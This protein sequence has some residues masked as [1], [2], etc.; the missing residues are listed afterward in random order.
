M[1]V[2][3]RDFLRNSMLLYEEQIQDSYQDTPQP[4]R[5]FVPSQFV[6]SPLEPPPPVLTPSLPPD[7]RSRLLIT[8]LVTFISAQSCCVR[9]VDRPLIYSVVPFHET[10]AK[11]EF[12]AFR[13]CFSSVASRPFLNAMARIPMLMA[14]ACSGKKSLC[15]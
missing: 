6:S 1:T 3:Y 11:S 5:F 13:H 4:F 2:S 8:S 15:S 12:V 9:A 14:F 7:M 10:S